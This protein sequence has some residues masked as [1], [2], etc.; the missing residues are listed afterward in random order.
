LTNERVVAQSLATVLTADERGHSRGPS[1]RIR[2]PILRSA[3][4]GDRAQPT[5]FGEVE[6]RGDIAE[7]FLGLLNYGSLASPLA[8][9]Q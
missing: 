2:S 1:S 7:D 4:L 5:G 8:D 9:F 3:K 6:R